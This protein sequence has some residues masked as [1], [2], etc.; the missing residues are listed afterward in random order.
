MIE[1]YLFPKLCLCQHLNISDGIATNKSFGVILML[2]RAG[3]KAIC[4][5]EMYYE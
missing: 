3:C 2:Q 4:L 5:T 1:G